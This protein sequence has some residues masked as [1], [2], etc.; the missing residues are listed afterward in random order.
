MEQAVSSR[1]VRPTIEE[2]NAVVY[3][4]A[5]QCKKYLVF[6]EAVVIEHGKDMSVLDLEETIRLTGRVASRALEKIEER[7]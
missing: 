1:R 6:V 3:S 2:V 5:S 7:K 4:P